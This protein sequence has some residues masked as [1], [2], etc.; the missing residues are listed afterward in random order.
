LSGIANTIHLGQGDVAAPRAV[1][2]VTTQ[3]APGNLVAGRATTT[4][5][6]TVQADPGSGL[7]PRFV[8]ATGP[9]GRPL[10]LQS[11]A[12]VRSGS[13]AQ[14][15]AYVKDGQPGPLTVRVTGASGTTGPFTSRTYLV[16]DVNG[17]GQVNLADLTAFAPAYLTHAG[18][19]FF[20]PAADAN[21]NG[22]IGQVDAVALEQNLTPPTPPIPLRVQI[23]LAP[24]DQ[25]RS[26]EKNSGGFTYKST[27][28]IV[29]RT[30]PGSLVFSDSGQGDFSFTGPFY[31]ADANGL[32]M[33]RQSLRDPLTNTEFLII[34]PF[35]HRL[36]AAFPIRRLGI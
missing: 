11:G 4:F 6:I 25:A 10:P 32:F 2:A 28:T 17:D 15:T 35:G 18:D 16:G 31:H 1:A 30:T 36:I 3:I 24:G 19:A 29:G 33:V 8:S 20:N 27:V 21:G 7:V 23:A 34:D 12:V 13:Q 26:G 5:G 9:D 22:F 14:V